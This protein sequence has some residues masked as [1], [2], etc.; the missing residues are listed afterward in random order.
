MSTFLPSQLEI[1]LTQHV[2]TQRSRVL[3]LSVAFPTSS[4]CLSKIKTN[5]LCIN[6]LLGCL[7]GHAF[8]RAT[9]GSLTSHLAPVFLQELTHFQNSQ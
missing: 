3:D 8:T 1:I 2:V 4:V 6:L 5:H 9:P 7:W